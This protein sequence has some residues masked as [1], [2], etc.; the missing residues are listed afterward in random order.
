MNAIHPA[1]GASLA[2]DMLRGLFIAA[3]LFAVPAHAQ[4]KSK[5]S[6]GD[7]NALQ[8][9]AAGDMAEIE[10]GKLAAQKGSNAEV[11]KFGQHMVDEHSKMLEEGKKFA[12]ANGVK[13]PEGP[14]RKH[15]ALMKKLQ[16]LSGAEFDRQYASNMV[17]DHEEDMKLAEKAAQKTKDPELKKLLENS[18]SH[19]REHLSMAHKMAADVGVAKGKAA[20]NAAR[21]DGKTS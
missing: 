9:L 19:I 17:S 5:L 21:S 12:D 4:D 1:A 8:K 7:K 18:A 11:K 3:V 13:P 20:G 6:H 10:A 15:K 16:G 14:D 2:G